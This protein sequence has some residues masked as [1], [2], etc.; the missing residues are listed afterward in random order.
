MSMPLDPSAASSSPAPSFWRTWRREIVRGGVLFGLVVCV[1]LV[2]SRVHAGMHMMGNLPATLSQLRDLKNFEIDPDG[3][4]FGPG[5]EIGD[6][7]RWHGPV[8]PSQQVW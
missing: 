4:Q 8:K 2:V 3:N 1:G 5:R 7:W 6:E